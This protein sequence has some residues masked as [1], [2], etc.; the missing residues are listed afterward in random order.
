MSGGSKK[1]RKSSKVASTNSN[2]DEDSNGLTRAVP[3]TPSVAAR[4]ATFESLEGG[5]A[6]YS[7][8]MS[9]IESPRS[10]VH[11]IIEVING[12]VT[13]QLSDFLSNEIAAL[14]V[15][16][17]AEILAEAQSTI[18]KAAEKQ[19][20]D[21]EDLRKRLESSEKALKKHEQWN[22]AEP[23]LV[24]ELQKQQNE[25]IVLNVGGVVRIPILAFERWKRQIFHWQ[26]SDPL[27]SPLL[28]E[29]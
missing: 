21:L 5:H 19:T 8:D 6:S 15:V 10:M 13:A 11:G 3:P 2:S 1:H 23:E 24:A 27:L 20:K 4:I 12:R 29:Y 26:H 14:L 28:S 17:R 18:A 7:S 22:H 16:T 25:Y 9:D